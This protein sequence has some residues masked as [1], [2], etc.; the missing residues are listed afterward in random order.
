MIALNGITFDIDVLDVDYM[1]R[2]E[3]YSKEFAEKLKTINTGSEVQ[4]VKLQCQYCH[5]MYDKVL[6]EGTSD[7]L[8]KGKL[9]II[10]CLKVFDE[11]Q[12]QEREQ[13]VLLDEYAN[14]FNPNRAA[15]RAKK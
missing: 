14:K 6:G 15:R 11:L 8:F 1:E 3:K 12:E 9:N 4:D 5:E 13:S 10:A 7:K 2:K